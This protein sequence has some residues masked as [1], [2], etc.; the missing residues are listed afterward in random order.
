M[1]YSL[2]GSTYVSASTGLSYPYTDRNFIKTLS[3]L[4]QNCITIPSPSGPIPLCIWSALSVQCGCCN[5]A[6]TVLYGWSKVSID[7]SIETLLHDY[8]TVRGQLEHNHSRDTS[9]RINEQGIV[10][11]GT[12][13]YLMPVGTLADIV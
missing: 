13:Q 6:L 10:A 7:R 12:Y 5:C 8:S 9:G 3:R 1:A 11:T 2:C 4:H